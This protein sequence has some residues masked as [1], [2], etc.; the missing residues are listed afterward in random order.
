MI[1]TMRITPEQSTRWKERA[2]RE[3]KKLSQWIRDR[4]DDA[5]LVSERKQ[6]VENDRK[7]MAAI[8]KPTRLVKQCVHG[9]DKGYHCWQCRGLAVINAQD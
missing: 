9:T 4:C 8:T 2:D 6:M 7:F 5:T 1:I 3:G